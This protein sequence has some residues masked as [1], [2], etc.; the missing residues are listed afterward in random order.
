MEE[1]VIIGLRGYLR[2]KLVILGNDMSINL[3]K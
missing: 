2:N 3:K 1:K